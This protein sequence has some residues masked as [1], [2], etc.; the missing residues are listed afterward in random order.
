M[1]GLI[2]VV[3]GV[4]GGSAVV[5]IVATGVDC[6]GASVVACGGDAAGDGGV[7]FVVL[8]VVCIWF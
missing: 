8:V 3:G 4:V 2:I 5:V 7:G 6:V 1:G